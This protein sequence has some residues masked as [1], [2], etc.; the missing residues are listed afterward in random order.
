M[1]SETQTAFIS[2][3]R[4][5]ILESCKMAYLNNDLCHTC[6]TEGDLL[7]CDSCP[8]TFHNHCLTIPSVISEQ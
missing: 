4:T 6:L 3:M 5:E 7:M 1:V 8:K 2:P